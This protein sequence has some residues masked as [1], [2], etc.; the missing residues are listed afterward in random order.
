MSSMYFNN[1]AD[2]LLRKEFCV[3]KRDSNN[4]CKCYRIG[5]KD[6]SSQDVTTDPNINRR[7]YSTRYSLTNDVRVR[8]AK[9]YSIGYRYQTKN[10]RDKDK[11]YG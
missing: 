5:C 2:Y 7:D 4:K 6:H 1:K 9:F 8:R 3:M 10:G 11:Y